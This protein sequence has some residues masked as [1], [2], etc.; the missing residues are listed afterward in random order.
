MIKQA[1]RNEYLLNA[2]F[3]FL[4]SSR[5]EEH[6]DRHLTFNTKDFMIS[7][8]QELL[9]S[10]TLSS[11]DNLI[12]TNSSFEVDSR[13][14]NDVSNNSQFFKNLN[15]NLAQSIALTNHD[16]LFLHRDDDLQFDTFTNSIELQ[17]RIDVNFNV[18]LMR[19]QEVIS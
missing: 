16:E 1:N 9:R 19:R 15:T 4:N 7:N 6:R 10:K 14:L 13:K 11:L 2:S 8:N 12:R 5:I 18:N 3:R 17:I